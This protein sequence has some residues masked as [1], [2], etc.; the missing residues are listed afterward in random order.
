MS[1]KLS[2]FYKM[3]CKHECNKNKYSYLL[4]NMSEKWACEKLIDAYKTINS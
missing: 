3:A 1:K 4:E 2:V